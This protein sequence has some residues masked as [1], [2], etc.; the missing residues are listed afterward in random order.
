MLNQKKVKPPLHRQLRHD[1]T[2]GCSAPA[3]LHHIGLVSVLDIFT[4]R[5]IRV[6]EK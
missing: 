4:D 1:Y 3:P 5:F 6:N 2:Q